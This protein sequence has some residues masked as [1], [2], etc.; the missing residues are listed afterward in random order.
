M[1]RN[2]RVEDHLSAAQ[3][4]AMLVETVA[5]GGN[6]LLNVGPRGIDAQI[7]DEQLTRL[8]WL[9]E[10]VT[11]HARA[12]AATRPWITPGTTTPDGHPVRYTARDTTVYAFVQGATAPI[13]LSEVCATP[14]TTVATVDGSALPWK[15][16]PAGIV[17]DV[18]AGAAGAGPL[19]VALEQVAAR[20]LG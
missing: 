3:V 2:E 4:V 16:S 15:D 9:A 8:D 7:P 6:L 20:P 18:P 14:T 17:V 1:N 13:T 11:P 12:I 5:K 10:W 19:V